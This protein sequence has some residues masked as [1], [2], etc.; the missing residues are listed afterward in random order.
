M[1]DCATM[2][3][4]LVRVE[5]HTKTCTYSNQPGGR[6][7]CASCAKWQRY[8]AVKRAIESVDS[9]HPVFNVDSAWTDSDGHTDP[10]PWWLR[11]NTDTPIS[12][13]DNYVSAAPDS[14]CW[15]GTVPWKG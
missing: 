15:W 6:L 7:D 14:A 3:G 4:F 8:L 1:P 12:A 11:W 2:K 9:T 10:R 13:H 5:A